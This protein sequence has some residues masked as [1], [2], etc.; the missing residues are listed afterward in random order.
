MSILENHGVLLS[1]FTMD[2]HILEWGKAWFIYCSIAHVIRY[3]STNKGHQ[4]VSTDIIYHICAIFS[5]Q[6]KCKQNVENMTLSPPRG[7]LI[8]LL[9]LPKEFEERLQNIETVLL[10]FTINYK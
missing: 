7:D 9:V 1:S 3:Y 4:R 6:T 5:H 10:N 2:I 8:T